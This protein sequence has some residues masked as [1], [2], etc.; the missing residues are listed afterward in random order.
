MSSKKWLLYFLLAAVTVALGIAVLNFITDPF[1]AFG[2]PFFNWH[3]Y[4]YTNN[5]RVAKI[6]YLDKN[7]S[8]YDSYIIGCSSTSSYS[9]DIFEKYMGGRFYNLIVYGADMADTE[10]TVAYILENYEVKNLVLNLYISNGET[11]DEESDKITRNLHWKVGDDSF[12]S[13]ASRYLFVNPR[14]SLEKIKSLSKNTYLP[15]TFDVFNEEKG[16]YDKRARDAED[17]GN[18]ETY[19]ER[20]PVFANYPT[21][22]HNLKNMDKA[23]KSLEK[24][25]ELCDINDVK[26][27]VLTSPV[28]GEYMKF[29]P[30]EEVKLFYEKIA[31]VTPFWDFS[32]SPVSYEPRY[33]Y[34]STHFRNCVGDMAAAKIFGDTSVYVPEDFGFYVTEDNVSEYVKKFSDGVKKEMNHTVELPVLMYHHIEE[35][36]NNDTII[37]P[38]TFKEHMNA[39]EANGWNTVSLKDIEKYVYNGTELPKKPVL[40]TFDDGYMSNYTYGYPILN[41]KGMKAAI[42]TV[43]STFGKDTYKDTKNKII[44]HFG[45]EEAKEMVE[46]GTIEIGSHT[47]DMH[48]AEQYE[49]KEARV[50]VLK[51]EGETEE[52][53]IRLLREDY[54]KSA[55]ITKEIT[56]K[57]NFALAYPHG[58]WDILSQVILNEMGVKITFD[59]ESGSNTLI[60][61]MP[62]SLYGLNRYNMHE[63][64]S[65]KQ[66][67]ELI[68]K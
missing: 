64:I 36:G 39:L 4:N 34:D 17:I 32:L 12:L 44:P 46:S 27:L 28:Y 45:F 18:K 13:Y 63:G 7:H 50:S 56:G 52:D 20:Y 14:Y 25:K 42:F 49:K 66:M 8:N 31:A 68:S 57:D 15:E 23:V 38:Q 2:D 19:L 41:K 16:V 30:E 51:L 11:Y 33:F 65:A 47:F 1:G 58:R 22:Y 35:N 59:T 60:K 5:P 53:Y 67:I 61:G 48:Q 26:L 43:G 3:S 9:T 29:F 40:I 10:K 6:S 24:I 37:T 55:A 54:K 62:Q 21:E